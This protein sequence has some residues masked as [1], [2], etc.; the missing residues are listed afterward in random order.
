MEK[1]GRVMV[2]L[3]PFLDL[4][5]LLSRSIDAN[6]ALYFFTLSGVF[7]LRLSLLVCIS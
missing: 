3:S 6:Y 7:L 4:R 2:I 5:F 1:G